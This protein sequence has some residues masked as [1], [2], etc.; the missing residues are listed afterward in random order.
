MIREG[1]SLPL[2]KQYKILHTLHENNATIVHRAV[3]ISDNKKVIIKLLKPEAKTALMMNGFINEQKYLDQFQYKTIPR[4]ID[5]ISSPTEYIHVFEDIEAS[6]LFELIVRHSFSL[7]ESL[8]I[9]LALAKTLHI[10]HKK[11]LIHA[12]VNPKNIIYNP[13]T[14]KLQLID[15]A[16]A[17]QIIKGE[18]FIYPPDEA[19]ANLFYISPEQTGLINQPVDHRSDLY[20]LGMSL[21]HLLLGHSPYEAIDRY[22]LIHKQIALQPKP[23]HELDPNI[24]LVVSQ[25][26][27]KL[28]EKNPYD[29]Y[30]NDES[31]INDLQH[32]LKNLKGTQEI[33]AFK[34]AQ[35]DH[36]QINIGEHLFGRQDE[37]KELQAIASQ[38]SFSTPVRLLVSGSS[39]VGKTRLIEE[40]FTYFDLDD[41]VI[42]RAKFE[43]FNDPTPYFSFRQ[44]F[45]QL[46]TRLMSQFNTLQEL[47]ALS[48]KSAAV[49]HFA[50][51][52]FSDLFGKTKRGFQP[53][54]EDMR[55]QLPLAIKEFFELLCTQNQK[56]LIFI[57]DLQWADEGSI[58]LMKEGLCSSNHSHLHIVCSYR[59]DELSK[60]IVAEKEVNLLLQ[61]RRFK[62]IQLQP[63]TK[64]ELSLML[65]SLLKQ[66]EDEID[67]LRDILYKKTNGN[68][69]YFKTFINFLLQ[70]NELYFT[71]GKWVYAINKIR[72]HSSSINIISL[73]SSK[74]AKLHAQQR[75]YLQYL[76]LLGSQ[77][78][79][80][81]TQTFM[82]T[83]G[84]DSDIISELEAE[85][86]IELSQ[87]HYQFIHDQ[88]HQNIYARINETDRQ[89]LHHK[90][91]LFLEKEYK[92]GHYHDILTLT[93]HLNHAYTPK[94]YPQKLFVYNLSAIEESL[95]NN[96][97]ENALRKIEWVDKALFSEDLW[98]KSPQRCF[99]YHYLKA[100]TLYLNAFSE[101]AFEALHTLLF[102][103]G[104][105][106]QRLEC[107]SLLKDISVTQGTH[108]KALTGFG[109]ELLLELGYKVPDNP[110]A[111]KK[112][113]E[114]LHHKITSHHLYEHPKEIL[115]LN[116]LTKKRQQK[117]I[118]LLVDYWEAAY[119][120]ADIDLMQWSALSII[121]IS[122]NHGN[123]SASCF[124][125]VLFGAQL[126]SQMIYKKASEFGTVA[127]KLNH[128]FDDRGMLPKVH[129]FVANF[130]NPYTR[131]L[132]SNIPLYQKSLYQS[133][134]NGDI[135][136]GTWANFLM[137]FSDFLSGNS[138][139]SLQEHLAQEKHFILNS[140]DEKM[141]AIFNQLREQVNRMQERDCE[142]EYD[143]EKAL[144]LWK[145]EQF[146]PALS[147]YAIM[148]AQEFF[149]MQQYDQGLACLKAY[150]LN[151]ENE[152]IMFPKI[153]LHLIRALLYLNHK[154]P[155]QH[156]E[157]QQCDHDLMIYKA[158]SK[159]SPKQF[160]CEQ[161]LLKAE[162]MKNEYALW[163]VAK[164]YDQSF[165]EAHKCN[166]SFLISL[167]SICAGRYFETLHLHDLSQF[168]FKEAVISLNQW[169]AYAWA[170]QLQQLSEKTAKKDI[171][172][173]L[174]NSSTKLHKES[175]PIQS[176]TANWQSL[177]KS[178]NAIS[179]SRN[180]TQLIQTLMKIILENA[181]A[182]KASLLLKEHESFKL[183]A[184]IDFETGLIDLYN[185]EMYSLPFIPYNFLAYIANT[186]KSLSLE[187][188]AQSGQFQ[189]DPYFKQQQPAS[190][191]AIPSILDGSVQA[192]LYL[193][194]KF[195]VTSL[196]AE[197][198]KTLE[199][200]LTQA[201]NVFQN[202]R[203]LD[204]LKQSED[205]LNKAQ[206]ISHLGSWHMNAT[207]KNVSCSAETY[208]IYGLE[209]FCRL[210]DTQWLLQQVHPDDRIKVSTA[211]EQ[212]FQH[213]T[214][215]D[216]HHR[217]LTND[218]KEKYVH[219]RA[220]VSYKGNILYLS[221]TI[222]DIT[223]SQISKE[224]I[225]R[226]SQVVN[227]NPYSTIITDLD[228]TIE[229]ANAQTTVM[230]G[231]SNSE[232]IGQK[233]NIFRSDVHTKEFYANM[234][235][236]IKDKKE[237]WKGQLF[238]KMKDGR[239]IDCLSTIFPIFD[240]HKKIINFVLIQEDITQQNLR[241]K[242]FLMQTRQAQMGEMLSM[243]AHQW[244][245]PLAIISALINAQRIGLLLHSV[246][247]DEIIKC[248]DDIET[249]VQYL[250]RTITDFRDFFRP[251]KESVLTKS[252]TIV[253]KALSLLEH[254]L[255]QEKIELK[256]Q[257]DSNVEYKTFE[258]EIEQV[259]LNLIKNAQDVFAERKIKNPC[260]TI[261]CE[262]VKSEAI[263]TV[264]DNAKGINK[265]VLDTLF[266]PYVSTKNQKQGTG[267]GLY[268]S[269][270]IVE[271]HCKGKLSVINT[272]EGAR[273][274]IAL[275]LK[276]EHA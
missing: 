156:E 199:L 150:V 30:Q 79:L 253:S 264:E 25:I 44:L 255:Q 99:R 14:L 81:L 106:N 230:S 97:Y 167:V 154:N 164:I 217:I 173:I 246:N 129:N 145:E 74:F 207:S 26:I 192:M 52:D 248:Y 130:I 185:L 39:G 231:Y 51:S 105:F 235:H 240:E 221:G 73:I 265:A 21:Y 272:K 66:D 10:I 92:R 57:D 218:Q 220:E 100:K 224:M 59:D 275:P 259:I 194:N 226:L 9:A 16:N 249:Q 18:S 251:D 71:E 109:D 268:M 20:S 86:F 206:E 241:D 17:H 98:E 104:N 227:Q 183:K 184:Q 166:N 77:Q 152:V 45:A 211:M 69:F 198:I 270:T 158:L 24:P 123:S 72:Q 15:F 124:A 204:S 196:D 133:K 257:C 43:Q 209:P 46:H 38:S 96:A 29:R 172:L 229:Y 161:L 120:L 33:K 2:K 267:L 201:L 242:L 219:Q 19:S 85:G 68:P 116:T 60:N 119:Y 203:L 12:D 138:L 125:Y 243:I 67:E 233:M 75:S 214:P 41:T 11:N 189:F 36:P 32:C 83:L 143:E 47:S 273:F 126:S 245:Q 31:L 271:D 42:L 176:E 112:R 262:E 177:I 168:Y 64:E 89:K 237:I 153:R 107:F 139:D 61:T 23:L 8:N 111:L 256:L 202:T 160:K 234:W 13:Q 171:E 128:L 159:T 87:T 56:I 188:P 170:K 121:N 175:S 27:S 91:A 117:I 53:S 157:K 151:D 236:V 48:S 4:L 193:E 134:L 210:L 6:S 208:R 250:T 180:S 239:L 254:H 80:K 232:L 238:N 93:H 90:I 95:K 50:F 3:R 212:T 127:L 102:K 215:F 252:S 49:L 142:F 216:I 5:V 115:K 63:L 40:F 162:T 137:H 222:Q 276:V 148:K 187:Y 191:L 55:S 110:S 22:E 178:F 155:L 163:D 54:P 205:K 149:F 114:S 101:A 190:C 131:P 136:F 28:I 1:D 76:S 263:I 88:I 62:N 274:T 165:K 197:K 182:S 84:Y 70:R 108:F 146:Y 37:I 58:R 82:K 169:G 135:V 225:M 141:I 213:G 260:I 181:T 244:R 35:H 261:K 247:P 65:Q 103:A 195:L 118:S 200:L 179:Q 122:F 144:A 228:S 266:L 186:K 223:E 132:S 34:I 78:D 174:K 269:K 147:W 94:H 258:H 113:V 7:L 140:G